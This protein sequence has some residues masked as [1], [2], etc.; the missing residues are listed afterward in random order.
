MQYYFFNRFF[1]YYFEQ[2][3]FIIFK[4][5]Y[6][7]ATFKLK[8]DDQIKS[9]TYNKYIISSDEDNIFVKLYTDIDMIARV[10]ISIGDNIFEQI[11][12]YLAESLDNA[13]LNKNI[14]S[15]RYDKIHC[16][17]YI[18]TTIDTEKQYTGEVDLFDF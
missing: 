15:I 12:E 4:G 8:T 1:L 13:A 16:Y 17:I 3:K 18:G 11:E 7:M 2:I 5:D 9:V 10:R 14:F 6:N